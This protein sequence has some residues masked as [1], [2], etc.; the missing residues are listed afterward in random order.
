MAKSSVFTGREIFALGIRIMFGSL[1]FIVT[2]T[3]ELHLA[4]PRHTRCFTSAMMT[5][6]YQSIPNE[7]SP[8]RG[9]IGDGA[10]AG[11]TVLAAAPAGHSMEDP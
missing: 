8:R 2:T 5:S 3:G 6:G 4:D 7:P 1:D 11:A 10:H 9:S